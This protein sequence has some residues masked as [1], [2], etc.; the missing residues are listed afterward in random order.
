MECCLSKI[1]KLAVLARVVLLQSANIWVGDSE[2]S[3]HCTNDRTKCTNIHKGS[4]ID[5]M[6]AHG[7]AM[8]A[9]SIMDIPG[10]WCNK[11]S[12]EQLKATLKDVQYNLKSNFNLF[13]TGK[14]IKEGWKLSGD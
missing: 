10:T 1:E 3:V 7:E 9:S 13:S 4:V 5:T 8:T 6:C 12:K 11:F 14:A 2:A